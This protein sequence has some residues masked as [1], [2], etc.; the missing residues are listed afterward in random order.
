MAG[1]LVSLFG[2][3][4]AAVGTVLAGLFLSLEL[5]LVAA[6]SWGRRATAWSAA[7][8]ALVALPGGAAFAMVSIGLATVAHRGLVAFPQLLVLSGVLAAAAIAAARAL[9]VPHPRWRPAVPGA[10]LASAAGLA[11]G[12]LPGLA[13]RYVAA[14]L[15]GGAAAIDLDA[16]ALGVPGGG[17]AAGYIG[18]A[19]MVVV[20]TAA[21]AIVVAGE[22]PIA[23]PAAQVH[24]L[25]P[26]RVRFLLRV[27]RR[28]APAVVAIA[29]A[30]RLLDAWLD[31]QPQ[32]PLFVG[33]AALAVVLLR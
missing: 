9:A 10:V 11:G 2:G 3:S 12:L 13:V 19:A 27:R 24:A 33:G 31:S 5:G 22:E 14:P 4:L 23:E 6:P 15:A 1:V 30:I 16:G 18:V 7:S 20:L 28:S 32:V 21:S 26:P 25:R 17:F 29:S 8:L